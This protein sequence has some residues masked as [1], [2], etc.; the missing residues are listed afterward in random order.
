MNYVKYRVRKLSKEQRDVVDCHKI[1]KSR[2]IHTGEAENWIEQG[3]SR[4]NSNLEVLAKEK[5]FEH[6]RYF[7]TN[8]PC[9]Q[10][11]E[12]PIQFHYLG[13]VDFLSTT[14]YCDGQTKNLLSTAGFS[15]K[16][17]IHYRYRDRRG[18]TKPVSLESTSELIK[19]QRKDRHRRRLRVELVQRT[20]REANQAETDS[21]EESE[22]SLSDM[23]ESSAVVI[24]LTSDTEQSEQSEQ[25]EDRKPSATE[26]VSQ[27]EQSEDL[28]NSQE[29]TTEPGDY[30]TQDEET[31][32]HYYKTTEKKIKIKKEE[33]ESDTKAEV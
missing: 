3:D 25:T 28:V 19:E 23:D 18:V 2:Y 13:T 11:W 21:I 20:Y 30:V 8:Y 4:K 32:K 17:K 9:N 24:P 6:T 7:D 31:Y 15:T 10:L 29:Q 12:R 14:T 22:S 5:S 16:P 1:T 27:E 33:E 26:P